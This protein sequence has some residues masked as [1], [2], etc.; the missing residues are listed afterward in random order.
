MSASRPPERAPLL[1]DDRTMAALIPR[2][3][4]RAHKG[5]H[6][7]LI[8]VAGSL[9]HLGAALLATQAA[10]RAGAGL[11]CLALPATLQPL[12]AGRVPEATTMA[13]PER[14]AME[15]EP[16]AA[17]EA[18]ARR[19]ADAL[20]VGPG[21]RPGEGTAA[22]V[23][24]LLREKGA[25]AVLDAEA[26][27]VL[28]ATSEWWTAFARR[29]VL[30]PHPGEFA[31]LDGSPVASEDAERSARAEAAA[32]RW[33]QVVVLKGA[34]TVIA[35]A[36]GRSARA[37]FKNPALATAGTG[38]VLAGTVAALLAQGAEPY[39]AARLGVYLHGVAAERA[40]ERLGDAG[41][42][43]SDLPLLMARARH[44]LSRAAGGDGVERRLGFGE[45][46]RSS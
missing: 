25:P 24:A 13:L 12:A 11:V 34:G 7:T 26:L 22:L 40:S 37:P 42:L 29:A 35:A 17:A 10:V 18:I 21:L 32:T 38:D 3:D 44:D 30:T 19:E 16:Q 36:D 46:L 2:R 9:D 8:I 33:D 43:A 1:L 14:S 6:G 39:D 31:R 28:A 23:L 5:S 41:L 27:N 4:E 20:L 45:R 15:V